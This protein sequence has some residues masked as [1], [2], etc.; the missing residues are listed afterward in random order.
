MLYNPND[1]NNQR[2]SR[3][4]AGILRHNI[5]AE[6]KTKD[7]AAKVVDRFYTKGLI[8]NKNAASEIFN[9]LNAAWTKWPQMADWFG[10]GWKLLREV[11]LVCPPDKANG[12]ECNTEMRPDRV[13]IKGSKAV[14]LDFKFG[15]HNHSKYSQQVVGYVGVLRLMGYDDVEGWLWY[16]FDNE[17]VKVC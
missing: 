2:Q 1:E 17:L 4:D 12:F 11:T 16:G 6:I 9:E 8:E 13:M 10:G 15:K 5:L 14:V 7:D 3:I